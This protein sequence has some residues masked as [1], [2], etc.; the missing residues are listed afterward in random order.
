VLPDILDFFFEIPFEFHWAEHSTVAATV[1][2]ER[3]SVSSPNRNV[4]FL[5]K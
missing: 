4:L 5:P 2:D 1:P 3:R